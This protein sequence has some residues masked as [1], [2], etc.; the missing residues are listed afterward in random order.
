[1]ELPAIQRLIAFEPAL[2]LDSAAPKPF[3]D[4]FMQQLAAGDVTGS[5]VTGMKGA[6][7][8]PPIFN[9]FPNWLLRR[10]TGMAMAGETKKAKP[11]D[12]TMCMLQPTLRYDFDLIVRMSGDLER[13][14]AVQTET[15]L[16]GGSKSPVY[17]RTAVAT[18]ERIL[19][20]VR[21]VELAGAHHGATGSPNRGGQP[22]RVAAEVKRFL[23]EG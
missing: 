1:M 8:G 16:L 12:I 7:M 15:L 3:Y 17:L 5:M 14:A 10:L 20:N 21:R 19:P 13:Y 11:G 9:L 23:A 22:E 2:F 4:R 18:L 6:Q